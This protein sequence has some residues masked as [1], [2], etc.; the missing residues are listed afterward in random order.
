[1]ITV[2]QPG[3]VGV[4]YT[5]VSSYFEKALI[6][7]GYDQ[8]LKQQFQQLLPVYY[9][10]KGPATSC[11]AFHENTLKIISN[12]EGENT[13]R[14]PAYGE[15]DLSTG[16]WLNMVLLKGGKQYVADAHVIWFTNSFVVPSNWSP[17]IFSGKFDID[18]FR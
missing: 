6:I 9:D 3:P 8:N 14:F 15:L 12:N 10:G 1:M 18:L 17:G 4:G 11:F 2:A 13:K 16:K 5:V 7:N